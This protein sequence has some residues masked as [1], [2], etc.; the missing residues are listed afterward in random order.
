MIAKR[1]KKVLSVSLLFM[2]LN[3]SAP[4]SVLAAEGQTS[5]SES[6]VSSSSSE[7]EN[8]TGTTDAS[9]QEPSEE[10][11]SDTR[12]TEPV[13]SSGSEN[14][15]SNFERSSPLIQPRVT[16]ADIGN[17][18]PSGH[19]LLT[20]T[21]FST[22]RV[23]TVI[24]YNNSTG[25]TSIYDEVVSW[26]NL[27][28]L[29][30]S[31]NALDA[32]YAANGGRSTSIAESKFSYAKNR[33]DTFWVDNASNGSGYNV[34]SR[35]LQ[36]NTTYY[37]WS[38]GSGEDDN[39]VYGGTD[40]GPYQDGSSSRTAGYGVPVKF[41]T[42]PGLPLTV[43]TPTFDQASASRDG[44]SIT[45]KAGTFKGEYVSSA[46]GQVSLSTNNFSSVAKT[47]TNISHNV[48]TARNTN[49]TYNQTVL[50][51]LS[52]GTR[53]KA[54]MGLKVTGAAD[55]T[56]SAASSYF[57]TANAMDGVPTVTSTTPATSSTN[58]FATV[59]AKYKVGADPAHPTAVK[60]KLKTNNGTAVDIDSSTTP[61]VDSYSIN[62]SSK[63][64]TVNLSKL[65]TKTSYK[66]E[67]YVK[68]ASG[69]WSVYNGGSEAFT[70][71]GVKLNIPA[72]KLSDVSTA[73]EPRLQLAEGTYTGDPMVSGTS[74]DGIVRLYDSAGVSIDPIT[75]LTSANGVYN[76]ATLVNGLQYGRRYK[77]AVLIRGSGND[78]EP[79]ARSEYV[80]TA[81]AI[82]GVPSM[83]S[84]TP[85]SSPTNAYATVKANYIVSNWAPDEAHPTEV[86]VKIKVNGGTAVDIDSSTTPKVD[87]YSINTATKEVTVN[88]SKLQTKTNYQ[89]EIYV[90]NASG[91]WS[92]Y[93]GA[94]TSMKP[95]GVRLSIPAPVLSDASTATEPRLKLESG[96]YTG[97]TYV[98]GAAA[99]DGFVRLYDSV[100]TSID[101]L[102]N[103]VS[104]N[105]V[106]QGAMLT[107]GL[108][109]GR[110]YK[111]EVL[112]RGSG[113][114]RE[115]SERSDYVYTANQVMTP[116][117]PTYNAPTNSTN[118]TVSLEGS[119]VV[120]TLGV[121]AAHPKTSGVTDG[122]DGQQ[123]LDIQIKSNV[124]DQ[125]AEWTS[126][127]NVSSASNR[128]YVG[129]VTITPSTKNV[130]WTIHSLRA[131]STYSVRY[132]VKNESNN[133]SA[134]S[135]DTYTVTTQNRSNGLYIDSV[136]TFDFGSQQLTDE[137]MNLPL[138][139]VNNA[140]TLTL[141]MENVGMSSGWELDVRM[142]P[143][144]TQDG[145]TL[146][147]AY[148]TF[149]NELNSY[150][151]GAWQPATGIQQLSSGATNV[152]ATNTSINLYRTQGTND[153]QGQHRLTLDPDTVKLVVP[154]NVAHPGS[155]YT[156]K[157]EW[158]LDQLP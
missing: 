76:A 149:E 8:S 94:S 83:V 23:S 66:V 4:L 150:S 119:Y 49:G 131:N 71:R 50:T 1:I 115:P 22:G 68:N 61:K 48:P 141:E 145:Q 14:P 59:K 55:Y 43:S 127:K 73:T 144:T 82:D 39:Y 140:E 32:T 29:S 17:L 122:F 107:S 117:N 156:G 60:V 129:E 151:G 138:S 5:S 56:R 77:A 9:S 80:Y 57:Y 52:P 152:P 157:L 96:T 12:E 99:T 47:Q 136:P 30:T 98:T 100:G 13:V 112:I 147:G 124:D 54:K 134:Y 78:H 93:R 111:A 155:I 126:L 44:T 67:V 130:K 70:P 37:F 63:E 28:F 45:M 108:E 33:S 158:I 142:T 31:P 75:N 121:D 109:F 72:P 153:G 116:T 19:T 95:K 40:F 58:A 154:A 64:V 123:G 15:T 11:T 133:W 135:T 89:A 102:R 79:S 34:L 143:L 88:L 84:T 137:L 2:L 36:P 25:I 92:K 16:L 101:P 35:D 118:A 41:K 20:Y 110:R 87:S 42:G 46:A 7:E 53:Y 113:N 104:E 27:V 97:E 6:S 3:Q 139:R 128:A 10:R 103:L 148:L 69:V 18:V 81:N 120:S 114:T 21:H 38:F 65:Q 74:T 51:G 132:R 85:A 106:Y 26:E 125:Y 146:T 90:K 86:R 24:Y 91:V 62:T 105:G